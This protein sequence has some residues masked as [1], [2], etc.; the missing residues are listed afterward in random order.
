[1]ILKRFDSHK[2]QTALVIYVPCRAQTYGLRVGFAHP[3]YGRAAYGVVCPVPGR[4][5]RSLE[6]Q[7]TRSVN[8]RQSVLRQIKRKML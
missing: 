7:T 5:G 2:R 6:S 3:P 1:M 4:H 8:A